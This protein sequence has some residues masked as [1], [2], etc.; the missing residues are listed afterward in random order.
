M[1]HSIPICE[2]R[3]NTDKVQIPLAKMPKKRTLP[4]RGPGGMFLPKS[5]SD[6][7]NSS[8]TFTLSASSPLDTPETNERQLMPDKEEPESRE[9]SDHEVSKD[10][11][12]DDEESLPDAQDQMQYSFQ[13]S[14]GT[15]AYHHL[16]LEN[17]AHE[18]SHQHSHQ[19]LKS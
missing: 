19:Q 14:S 11:R 12:E 6:T 18:P 1:E 9:V 3:N 17:Q 8:S 4:L 7:E 13:P 16:S 10:L 2:P 5:L 15:Q